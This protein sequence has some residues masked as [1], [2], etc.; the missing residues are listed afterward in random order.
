MPF[1]GGMVRKL[2]TC[3]LPASLLMEQ[4]GL[5]PSSSYEC[6]SPTGS[7][8][9]LD[10][11]GQ[12]P[13]GGV[14][15]RTLTPNQSKQHHS[16]HE[17]RTREYRL[18]QGETPSTIMPVLLNGIPGGGG[19]ASLVGRTSSMSSATSTPESKRNSDPPV[20]QGVVNTSV[21]SSAGF[22]PSAAVQ[23]IRTSTPGS[24]KTDGS[25]KGSRSTGKAENSGKAGSAGKTEKSEGGARNDDSGQ[26]H[27]A[28]DSPDLSN[29]SW[30]DTG[31][32]GGGAV[33]R[34]DWAVMPGVNG[35][36]GTG[37][38][39]V[40]SSFHSGTGMRDST[41]SHSSTTSQTSTGSVAVSRAIVGS[42][43]PPSHSS[44]V[45]TRTRPSN[46][47]V[48][49]GMDPAG[50]HVSRAPLSAPHTPVHGHHGHHAHHHLHHGYHHSSSTGKRHSHHEGGVAHD[51]SA[52][53]IVPQP[54]HPVAA[55]RNAKSV[56]PYV[57]PA[58][59]RV[60]S[61]Q[62]RPQQRVLYHGGVAH[63][64]HNQNNSSANGLMR[65]PM[66]AAQNRLHAGG[67]GVHLFPPT[68]GGV[69]SA[70][71]V[72]YSSSPATG[73]TSHHQAPPPPPVQCYNCGKRG[74]LGST[75][76]GVTMDVT[77][78]SCEFISTYGIEGPLYS[79]HHWG[80]KFCPLYR[81]GL[82][83][84]K[85]VPKWCIWGKVGGVLISGVA[86][87][88]GSTVFGGGEDL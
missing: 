87:M 51:P 56:H 39:D 71:G 6:F 74:H 21:V 36:S 84:G 24:G 19:V 17:M 2:S 55:G 8:C 11:F 64:H 44:N 46:P 31:E 10:K 50:Y 28:S 13:T 18:S 40:A 15:V 81:G 26:T 38:R 69:V 61:Q 62:Q 9:S 54:V 29:T 16:T 66:S 42:V 60:P 85:L 88:R 63:V 78:N 45:G 7:T 14:G 37:S 79:G 76:P 27:A 49:S 70:G 1:A 82:I 77:D 5:T 34:P 83:S 30:A 80:T 43:S 25:G 32:E 59:V 73:H 4:V 67:V 65:T 20:L 52:E 12:G 68:H 41:Q 47:Q 75:C 48:H 86:C 58:V 57:Y 72:V 33:S 35:V 22:T 3:S 53:I 23:V